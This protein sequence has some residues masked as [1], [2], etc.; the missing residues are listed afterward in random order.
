M[1]NLPTDA[2]SLRELSQVVDAYIIADDDGKD[3]IRKVAER[4]GQYRKQA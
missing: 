4:E 1:P 2:E 3:L